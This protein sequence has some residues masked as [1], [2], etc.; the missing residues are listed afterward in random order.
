MFK[1]LCSF[2]LCL[3][4][5]LSMSVS[6]FA[7]SDGKSVSAGKYGTLTGQLTSGSLIRHKTKVTSNPDKAILYTKLSCVN[8]AG[9]ELGKYEE[10]SA[11]G[12]KEISGSLSSAP[13]GTTKIYSTHEVRGGTKNPSKAISLSIKV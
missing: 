12:K 1:K 13:S 6:A 3:A 2:V 4:M 5:I 8:A 11:R 9:K 10:H 7:A